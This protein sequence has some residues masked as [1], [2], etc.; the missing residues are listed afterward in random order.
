MEEP[1]LISVL[2][3][4]L[5]LNLMEIPVPQTIDYISRDLQREGLNAMVVP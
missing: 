2:E 1:V 4:I 5:L 3:Q